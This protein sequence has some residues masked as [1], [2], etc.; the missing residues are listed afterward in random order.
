[1][2]KK[3][4]SKQ[5]EFEIMKLVLDKFLWAG[6]GILLY[7][8]YVAIQGVSLQAGFWIMAAGAL[9]LVLFTAIIIRE[10]EILQ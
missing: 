8:F 3:K 9:L 4:L 7:G 10:Y 5:Q 1:M 6:L 2:A